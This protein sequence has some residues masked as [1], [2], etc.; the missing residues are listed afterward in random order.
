MARPDPALWCS[1]VHVRFPDGSHPVRGVSLRVYPGQVFALIGESGAG[2]TLLCRALYGLQRFIPG[3]EVMG[4]I[5]GAAEKAMIFQDPGQ[6]LNPGL[7]IEGHFKEFLKLSPRPSL[8]MEQLLRYVGLPEN[9]EFSRKKPRLLSGGQQQRVMIALSLALEPKVLFADEAVTALDGLTRKTVIELLRQL[10]QDFG[11]GII[12]VT[13]D[14]HV[15]DSLADWV[16]VMYAGRIVELQSA[17]NLFTQPLH[18]YTKGLFRSHPGP[19]HRNSPLI[20]LPGRMP[21]PDH[22]DGGCPF[23]DRCPERMAVCKQHLPEMKELS[24]GVSVSCHRVFQDRGY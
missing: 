12:F 15:A 4:T 11:L 10:C 7:S 24:R 8:T 6:F 18:P 23:F 1:N 13:H 5:G 9:R 2:K 14:L 20:E 3:M 21:P 22:E 17:E 16:G 19:E